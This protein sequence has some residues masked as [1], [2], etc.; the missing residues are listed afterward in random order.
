MALFRNNDNGDNDLGDLELDKIKSSRR[1]DA[2]DGHEIFVFVD[3]GTKA[4]RLFFE[5]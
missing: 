4:C 1:Y 3:T 5:M 2:V